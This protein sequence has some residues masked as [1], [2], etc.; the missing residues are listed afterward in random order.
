[1]IKKLLLTTLSITLLCAVATASD[2]QKLR[3][4]IKNRYLNQKVDD[5]NVEKIITSFGDNSRWEKIN[6]ADT[7]REG[8]QHL[9]HLRNMVAVAG[10]YKYPKSKY[11]H[12]AQAR[13][14]FD[15]AL[16]YWSTKRF[17][18]ENWHDNE[19]GV[20]TQMVAMLFI[21]DEDL[22][23]KQRQEIEGFATQGTLNS[24][25][26]RPSGDRIKLGDLEA[27]QCLFRG[28]DARLTE[29]IRVI[30]GEMK[31]NNKGRGMQSD[32]SFHHR[33]DRVNNTLSY[34]TGF[35]DAYAD[36]CDLVKNTEYRF[37]DS[38]MRLA[39][40]YY[41]DG[42][43]KQMVYGRTVD[44]GVLNRDITR[45]RESHTLSIYTPNKFIRSTDYRRAELQQIVNSRQG[46]EFTPAS[47]SKFFWESDH[48]VFQRP[49]FYTSVRMHSNR[50]NNMEVPY[51]SEGILNHFRGDGTNY[52]SLTGKEYNGMP[53]VND[54]HRIA[55]VTTLITAEPMLSKDVA[56]RGIGDFTGAVSDGMYGA[57]AF[58]F[59]SAHNGLKARK[60][61]FFFDNLYVCLGAGIEAPEGAKGDVATT[62]NQQLLMGEVV[63]STTEST[64]TLSEGER[65]IA[66]PKWIFHNN[67]GYIFPSECDVML[68]NEKAKGSWF[69]CNKQN[70]SPKGEVTENVFKLWIEQGKNPSYSYVVVPA[71]TKQKVEAL[72][73][74]P[75][76]K[77]VANTSALQAVEQASSGIGYAV[78]YTSGSVALGSTTLTCDTPAIVMVRGYNGKIEEIAI[79]DPARKATKVKLTINKKI[80]TESDDCAL[81]YNG[82]LTAITVEMPQDDY[83]GSTIIIKTN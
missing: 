82:K 17:N 34:G 14:V 51:N 78:F 58:D 1:M 81:S 2:V 27:K 33:D 15:R 20:P 55:G 70:S 26:A 54:W 83:A 61:W 65:K 77:I 41:L 72:S 32:F 79:S 64:Q 42:I 48:F 6:Y 44:T 67:T 57:A 46:K 31:M 29:V 47:Y 69:L 40:D 50:C 63:V 60:S 3:S 80:K 13:D 36:W 43:C 74:K 7:S 28:D 39:I 25:G 52:L 37:S 35:L 59:T 62:L 9:E 71:T 75:D 4:E 53:P 73:K 22:T 8:F 45:K 11:Y 24:W 56:K 5:K 16:S 12:S 66:N 10:A 21:M 19:I 23:A 68:K 49:T 38:S 30:E 76:Y 18:A